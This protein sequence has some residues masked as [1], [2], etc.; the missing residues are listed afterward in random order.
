MRRLLVPGFAMMLVLVTAG[1]ANAITFGH[2]DRDR[3]PNVG[4]L[5]ADWDTESPGPDIVCTGTLIDERVF[6]TAA[7]CTAFLD[8]I[9][10]ERVRVT[11]TPDYDEDSTSLDGT[12]AG[13]YVTH[14]AYG[15]GGN[16]DPNDIAVV[17]LD[18]SPGVQPAR[19]PRAR[20]LNDLRASH[21]LDDRTFTAVGYGTV[22]EDKTGGF[23]PLFF[24]GKRR[25]ATQSA[26]NL[27]K[28]WLLL[29]M[30]PSTGNGGTC[31]G[32]SGGPHFLGGVNSNLVVS[33]TITG[34]A[35]CRA[36]DKTYRLDTASA[37]NFLDDFVDLP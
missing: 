3:H 34:D 28:A 31:Y 4:A 36:T 33:T 21:E 22:R 25:Y 29:S 17:L 6:L 30:N 19:L 23:H 5:L 15:T 9:G 13:S 24:D 20:L 2:P 32:D 12:F 37:R 27:E 26:L 18:K 14:P 1:P 7:H 16:N 8:S 10:I 35:P 11:F